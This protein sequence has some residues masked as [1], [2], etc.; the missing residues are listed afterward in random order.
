MEV[1]QLAKIRSVDIQSDLINDQFF[2]KGSK[3]SMLLIL[4]HDN[5][6]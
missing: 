3:T 4:D 1:G 5:Q 6:D 2:S